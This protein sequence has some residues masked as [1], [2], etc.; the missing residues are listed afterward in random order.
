ME[1]KYATKSLT[2]HKKLFGFLLLLPSGLCHAH[3]DKELNRVQFIMLLRELLKL[4][5]KNQKTNSENKV[6]LY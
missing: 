2:P 5:K 3:Q 1:E 4:R 6:N